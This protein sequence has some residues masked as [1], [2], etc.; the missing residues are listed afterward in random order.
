MD[1]WITGTTNEHLDS[2]KDEIFFPSNFPKQPFCWYLFLLNV[3]IYQQHFRPGDS[4]NHDETDEAW[5]QVIIKSMMET[6]RWVSRRR[7][8]WGDFCL[9]NRIPKAWSQNFVRSIFLL[10]WVAHIEKRS[11]KNG[12]TLWNLQLEVGSWNPSGFLVSH[13]I[14]R[15][16]QHIFFE[17]WPPMLRVQDWQS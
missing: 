8:L 17:G 5:Y 6:W 9:E 7:G 13:F 11:T 4:G 3:I 1:F 14:Y 16:F 15:L 2:L 12:W 10:G